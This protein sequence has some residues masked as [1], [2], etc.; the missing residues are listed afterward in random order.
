MG[1]F[2]PLVVACCDSAMGLFAVLS[3]SVCSPSEVAGDIGGK[4]PGVFCLVFCLW[5]RI[6]VCSCAGAV[7]L[8][9]VWAFGSAPLASVGMALVNIWDSFWSASVCLLG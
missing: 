5:G 3:P 1:S 2:P 8:L 4:I 9:E 7:G 6:D